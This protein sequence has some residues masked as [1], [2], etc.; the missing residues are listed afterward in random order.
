MSQLSEND[1]RSNDSLPL[2]PFAFHLILMHFFNQ[3]ALGIPE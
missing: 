1:K 3:I 2:S